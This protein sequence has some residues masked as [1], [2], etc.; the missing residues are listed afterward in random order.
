MSQCLLDSREWK[1]R[2]P[3]GRIMKLDSGGLPIFSPRGCTC[4]KPATYG[5]SGS[6]CG[7]CLSPTSFTLSER[8][9]RQQDSA[10]LQVRPGGT[11]IQGAPAKRTVSGTRCEPT[12]LLGTSRAR[13]VAGLRLCIPCHTPGSLAQSSQ[14]P[15]LMAAAPPALRNGS[16]K[17]WAKA[18]MSRPTPSAPIPRD[19]CGPN[20]A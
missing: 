18:S 17:M 7:T 3:L 14:H 10:N 6:G 1:T 20:R 13:F 16:Q 12:A 8:G 15:G 4:S 2:A 19:K 5:W 9:V 11:T